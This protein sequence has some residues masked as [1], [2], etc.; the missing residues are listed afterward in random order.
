MG[1]RA[2]L[3]RLENSAESEIATLL[4]QECGEEL[5]VREGIELDLVADTWA[6]GMW[7]RGNE[8]QWE[9][10]ENVRL[11]RNHPHSE[12]SLINKR[13]GERLFPWGAIHEE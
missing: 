3:R 4:C 9:T 7:E 13:T 2:R 12:L 6:E 8:V 11:I 10:P 5:R 1:V